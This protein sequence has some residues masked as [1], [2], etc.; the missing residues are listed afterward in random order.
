MKINKQRLIA[1][2][3]IIFVGF[4][5]YF[6]SLNSPFIWDDTGLI[7]HN[8]LIKDFKYAPK[9]FLTDLFNQKSTGNN[10][11]RPLQSLSYMLDYHFYKLDAYGYHLTNVIL[12]IIVGLLVYSFIL[13]ISG[14]GLTSL[15]TA[16]FF[17]VHPIHVETVTYISGR[18]DILVALFLLLSLI[19]F[20]RG[21]YFI[22]LFSFILAMLSKEFALIFPVFLLFYGLGFK[23]NTQKSRRRNIFI[24]LPFFIAASAYLCL[25]S[26]VLTN[27]AILPS[28]DMI[29]KNSVFFT[30]TIFLYLMTLFLPVNLHM[31][32]AFKP[33]DTILEAGIILSVLGVILLIIVGAKAF[34][35]GGKSRLFSFGLFWFF[36]FLLPYSGIFAINAYFAEHFCYMSSIGIFFIAA[37]AFSRLIKIKEIFIFIPAVLITMYTF[38]TV[39]YNFIWRNP[40]LF[41][42]RILKFSPN[43]YHAYNNLGVIEEERGNYKK[44]Q[45]YYL[46]A[47]NLRVDNKD[48]AFLSLIRVIYLDGKEDAAM[49]QLEDFIQEYPRSHV[50]W[51]SLGS[52]YANKGEYLKAID[53]YN[54]SLELGSYLEPKYHYFL[55]VALWKSGQLDLAIKELKLDRKSVV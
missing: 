2:I 36:L 20:T 15:L 37:L 18:A 24:Y 11:Y 40:K 22:S 28:L 47:L 10:F 17:M 1:A 41:Y 44:A 55:G 23:Y 52:M 30:K 12:Q 29:F 9:I 42:L 38:I 6:N 49:V 19:L 4:G 26:L 43:S 8:S 39:E 21:F 51:A 33:A 31:S 13:I 16:L 46:K 48:P 53:A 25:R 7:T 3:L 34:I 14:S 27:N 35:K 5:C 32:Y 45:D 50:A 54:K